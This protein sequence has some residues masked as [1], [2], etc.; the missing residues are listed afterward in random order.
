MIWFTIE[1]GLNVKRFVAIAAGDD[2]SIGLKSDGSIVAWGCRD[3]GSDFGQCTAPS[4]NAG[5]MAIAAS[6]SHSLGLIGTHADFNSDGGV[7]LAD[8][9]L[10]NNYLS[11]PQTIGPP[12]FSRLSLDGD[13]DVDLVDFAAFQNAFG[14]HD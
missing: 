8:L 14:D 4:P 5:F 11:G 2:Q 7:D 6:Y 10:L 1:Y 13:P 12:G 9:S 3:F